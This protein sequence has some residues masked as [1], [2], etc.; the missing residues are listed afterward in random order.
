MLVNYDNVVVATKA[1]NRLFA[2]ADWATSLER[3]SK[4]KEPE[5]SWGDVFRTISR[6]ATVKKALDE[7]RP[8]RLT[9]SDPGFDDEEVCLRAKTYLDSWKRRNYGAMAGLISPQLGNGTPSAT[10]GRVREEFESWKLDDYTLVAAAFEAA[11]VCEIDIDLMIDGEK[12]PANAMDPGRRR[13]RTR[14]AK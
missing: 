8:R 12:K 5:P 13:G 11:A 3:K 14:N 2:V 7:W 9:A 1:W 4:P 10:A 6:N